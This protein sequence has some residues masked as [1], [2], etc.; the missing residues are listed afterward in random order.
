M[1][2]Q[3]D[4]Q[5]NPEVF[6]QAKDVTEGKYNVSIGTSLALETLFGIN[7]NIPPPKV[8]PFNDY[9]YLVINVKTLLRNIVGAVNKELKTEWTTDHY[10]KVLL[11]EM[12]NIPNIVSDQSHDKLHV[13]YYFL[14]YKSLTKEYPNALIRESRSETSLKSEAM[15]KYAFDKL[16]GM[17]DTLKVYFGDLVVPLDEKSKSVMITH[18]PL[19]L[20]PYAQSSRCD[21]LETHTGAIKDRNKWYTKLSGKELER[22][23]FTRKTIQIFGDGKTFKGLTPKQREAILSFA[24]ENHWNQSTTDRL[25]EKQIQRLPDKELSKIISSL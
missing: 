2:M 10:V 23:P 14:D 22:I 13:I 19:D 7:D 24:K 25:I 9:K 15:E 16:K 1:W 20:V 21:L 4:N 8:L 17:K 3:L 6:N 11:E 5:Q 12:G 18:M